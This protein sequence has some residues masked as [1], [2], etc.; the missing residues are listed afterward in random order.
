MV[1]SLDDIISMEYSIKLTLRNGQTIQLVGDPQ[2]GLN[3]VQ[4]A[5][6]IPMANGTAQAPNDS[7]VENGTLPNDEKGTNDYFNPNIFIEE[8]SIDEHPSTPE[9][10]L[11]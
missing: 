7:D 6:S 4:A 3:I 10:Y 8:E 1:V 5:F 9:T 2:E 11:S